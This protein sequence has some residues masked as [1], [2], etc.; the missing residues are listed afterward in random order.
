MNFFIHHLPCLVFEFA[1]SWLWRRAKSKAAELSLAFQQA[2][3]RALF[4]PL[5]QTVV[6]LQQLGLV[7]VYL[8]FCGAACCLL[9]AASASTKRAT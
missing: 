4:A 1:F 6:R 2:F 9:D 3:L 7:A 8:L 5:E